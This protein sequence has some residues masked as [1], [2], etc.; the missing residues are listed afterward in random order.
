MK[1]TERVE[2]LAFDCYHEIAALPLLHTDAV[3]NIIQTKFNTMATELERVTAERDAAISLTSIN[4]E[5]EVV[6][7]RD[8]NAD[9]KRQVEELEE[10]VRSNNAAMLAALLHMRE[11]KIEFGSKELIA[12]LDEIA[13]LRAQLAEATKDKERLDWLE[14]NGLVDVGY[15]LWDEDSDDTLRQAIDAAIESQKGA[16]E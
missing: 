15:T 8:E 3:C 2:Q 16:N 6:K 12:R 10:S 11:N 4:L 9:L 5:W 1:P 14:K 13:Q 7:C